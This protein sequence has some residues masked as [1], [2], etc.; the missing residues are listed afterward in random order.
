MSDYDPLISYMVQH[1]ICTPEQ[2]R[3]VQISAQK[4][5][6]SFLQQLL[7]DGL[8]DGSRLSQINR[9]VYNLPQVMLRELDVRRELSMLMADGYL[10][11]RLIL[12]TVLCWRSLNIKVNLLLLNQ[13]WRI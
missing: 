13:L 3:E 9:E 4:K 10:L 1:K 5:R 8:I 12:Q 2:I 7:S 6:G 11:R